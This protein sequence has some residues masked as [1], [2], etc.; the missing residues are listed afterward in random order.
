MQPALTQLPRTHA[1]VEDRQPAL[2]TPLTQ[3]PR[4]HTAVEDRQPALNAQT[5]HPA[6]NVLIPINHN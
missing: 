4:T 5:P 1:A 2:Y 6:W 3:L